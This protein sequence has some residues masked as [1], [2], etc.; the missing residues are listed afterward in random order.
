MI[1]LLGPFT[2]FR[3]INLFLVAVGRSIHRLL[4]EKFSREVFDW[5]EEY[6]DGRDDDKYSHLVRDQNAEVVANGLGNISRTDYFIWKYELDD[7]SDDEIVSMAGWGNR[8]RYCSIRYY[9]T[10]AAHFAFNCCGGYES[11]NFED[12]QDYFFLNHHFLR[13]IFGN[14]FRPVIF[15]PACRTETTISLAQS[16]YESRDFSSLPILADCLEEAGCHHSDVLNHCR[17]PKQVHI[18]GCWVVD[19]ILGKS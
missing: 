6:A 18:R 14:P 17:D 4:P 10:D 12:G 19:L 13:D 16:A 9:L 2:T 15:D 11:G 7:L 5:L 3:K 8:I 1:E